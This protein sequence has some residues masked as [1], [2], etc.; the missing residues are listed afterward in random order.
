[1]RPVQH[2]FV[3]ER[4]ATG[5][6]GTHVGLDRIASMRHPRPPQPERVPYP[7]PAVTAAP[8]LGAHQPPASIVAIYGGIYTSEMLQ[9]H[10][11]LAPLARKLDGLI[12]G[13]FVRLARLRDAIDLAVR[14]HQERVRHMHGQVDRGYGLAGEAVIGVCDAAD[15]ALAGAIYKVFAEH[16]HFAVTYQPE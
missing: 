15:R 14:F 8:L 10:R 3:D 11:R 4:R 9:Q 13:H 16:M 7:K 2:T 6:G 5:P 12:K 1:R